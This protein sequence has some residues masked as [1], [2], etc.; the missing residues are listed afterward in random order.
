MHKAETKENLKSLH[1]DIKT[2][3]NSLQTLK[4]ANIN[5]KFETLLTMLDGKAIKAI[6]GDSSPSVCKI[7]IPST[8]PKQMNK[9]DI[10]IN[11][12][13][14]ENYLEFGLSPLHLWI[15]TL[16]CMLHISYRMKLKCWSV[17]GETNK[18]VMVDEKQR[19]QDELRKK[20]GIRVDYPVPD[21]GSSNTGNIARNFFNNVDIVSEITQLDKK[22]LYQL[23]VILKTLNSG[24]EINIDS[25]EKYC[26]NTAELFVAK[27]DWYFMPISI[28]KMLFHS[29]QI[30]QKLPIPI[31]SS[32]EEALEACHKTIR[33]ARKYHTC[34]VSRERI[35]ED[36]YKW[37]MII[38]D[39]IIAENTTAYKKKKN[40]NK[41]VVKLL[42]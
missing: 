23:S 39:P 1:D 21:F 32:S 40:I 38:S 22:L 30:I 9:L 10:I 17:R 24:Y 6:M 3:I 31:G 27:Y 19:I 14:N 18:K 41:D 42:K 34:K 28:H 13:I 2:E 7:C 4:I 35:N 26:K 12:K 15:N 8:T 29:K 25:F 37:L 33:Y 11:K 20:L 5:I 36:L 16:E